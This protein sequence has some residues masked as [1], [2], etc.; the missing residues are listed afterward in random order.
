MD[1]RTEDR[2]PGPERVENR[3]V[4]RACKILHALATLGES[5]L[6][7]IAEATALCKPTTLRILR[8]LQDGGLVEA[9]GPEYSRHHR[10]HLGGPTADGLV[11]A[12]ADAFEAAWANTHAEAVA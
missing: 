9:T 6:T 10:W 12:L 8:S 3:S 5:P 11:N 2:G 1:E 7:D 4:L